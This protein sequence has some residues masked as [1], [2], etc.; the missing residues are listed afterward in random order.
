MVEWKRQFGAVSAQC[1]VSASHCVASP[2]RCLLFVRVLHFMLSGLAQVV[3]IVFGAFGLATL[4]FAW[5][6]R[7][8]STQ[9]K[10]RQVQHEIA[11]LREQQRQ[12]QVNT[13][14]YTQKHAYTHMHRERGRNGKRQLQTLNVYTRTVYK[15]MYC[16]LMQ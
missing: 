13:P 9:Q 2:Y 8:L 5:L 4:P 11:T 7:G 14:Q 6:Y 16:L 3:W 12:L 15:N 10:Q 1:P